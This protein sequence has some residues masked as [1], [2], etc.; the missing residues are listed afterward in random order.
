MRTKD[1]RPKARRTGR[2][3]PFPKINR[4]S[5]P[6]KSS[7]LHPVMAYYQITVGGGASIRKRSLNIK[8]KTLMLGSLA[9]LLLT[10]TDGWVIPDLSA[11]FRV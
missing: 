6:S 9:C 1:S 11:R 3:N 7:Y 4:S 10:G 8:L 5:P 2:V